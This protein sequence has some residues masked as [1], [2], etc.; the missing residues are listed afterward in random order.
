MTLMM[1]LLVA[2]GAALA[3]GAWSTYRRRQVTAWN[4]ELE[5][6]FGPGERREIS[7][8]RSL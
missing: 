7:L 2:V 8:H 1:M 6:A 4:R 5:A 3:A